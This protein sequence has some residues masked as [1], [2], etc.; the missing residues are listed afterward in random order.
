MHSITFFITLQAWQR[1]KAQKT[2]T[3]VIWGTLRWFSRSGLVQLNYIDLQK[4]V[5]NLNN[6]FCLCWKCYGVKV[7]KEKAEHWTCSECAFRADCGSSLWALCKT[8]WPWL[9][10]M[11]Q[12]TVNRSKVKC[13]CERCLSQAQAQA[14]HLAFIWDSEPLVRAE[15]WW[16]SHMV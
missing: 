15:P 6:T 2:M 13:I 11:L 1:W 3:G 12:F 8:Y 14:A 10:S 4:Q 9:C 5:I 7:S 16:S